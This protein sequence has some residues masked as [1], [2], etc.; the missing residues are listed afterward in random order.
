MWPKDRY[1][2]AASA[3]KQTIQENFFT[4]PS[5]FSLLQEKVNSPPPEPFK[6]HTRLH[7]HHAYTHSRT[8]THTHTHARTGKGGG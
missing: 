4:S 3:N 8:H 1:P 5:S 2:I 7:T 6:T